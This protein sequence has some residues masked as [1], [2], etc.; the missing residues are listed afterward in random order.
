MILIPVLA[1]LGM[2]GESYHEITTSNPDLEVQVRYPT[3]FR[4]KMIDAVTVSLTNISAQPFAT[5]HI[6]FDREYVEG[7]SAVIFTP[8]VKHITDTVY[9]VELNDLQPGETRIISVSI[10]AEEYGR[11]KGTITVTP[12]NWEALQVS[13]DTFTFP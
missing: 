6:G 3:R 8:S 5:A 10:Q 13:I 11:H 12:E 1:L 4:Y 2:F 7:F 9:L